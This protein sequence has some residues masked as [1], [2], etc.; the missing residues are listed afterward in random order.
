MATTATQAAAKSTGIPARIERTR[1]EPG[2]VAVWYFGAASYIVKTPT[3]IIYLDPYVG[4]TSGRVVPVPFYPLEVKRCDVAICSHDHGDHTDKEVLTAWRDYLTPPV[5]GPAASIALARECNYPDDKLRPLE[6]GQSTQVNDVKIT[7]L[8]A[9]DPLAQGAN[10]HLMQA[11]GVSLLH[12]GDTLYF[13][14][15]KDELGGRDIDVTFL[16]I[17]YNPSG[18]NYYLTESDAGRAARDIGTRVLV[19]GHWDIWKQFALDP[20]R[21]KVVAEWYAPE[22]E[23]RIPRWGQKMVFQ[24]RK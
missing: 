11:E 24:A 12:G 21:I 19:P 4:E 8:K 5:V 1:V 23:V 22:L 17:G 3:T 18:Y 6:H 13:K 20:K 15:M 16:S 14:E 2:T 7:A 9:I 10:S